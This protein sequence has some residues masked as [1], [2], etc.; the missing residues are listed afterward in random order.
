MKR[1]AKTKQ[2]PRRVRRGAKGATKAMRTRAATAK[3]P[4]DPL[5]SLI[6]A[7]AQVLGLTVDPAWH[8]SIKFNLGLI[9]RLGAL[10]KDF[11]LADDTEPGP[12]FHA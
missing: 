1:R 3:T 2:T 9:L 8:G 11:P 6:A 12:V 5:D 7:S 4:R 10:V